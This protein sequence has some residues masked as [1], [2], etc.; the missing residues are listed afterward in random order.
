MNS[1]M[2]R[3]FLIESRHDVHYTWRGLPFEMFRVQK[4]KKTMFRD[5]WNPE[6]RERNLTHLWVQT[7][8]S[9]VT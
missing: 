6:E 5:R 8:V 9:R 4:D 7:L 2:A 1:Q 3:I